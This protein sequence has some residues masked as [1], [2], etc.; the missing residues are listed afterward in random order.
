MD[1]E[2]STARQGWHL[3]SLLHLFPPQHQELLEYMRKLEAR[4]EKVA[5]E[6]WNEDAATEDEEAVAGLGLY[7]P[8]F[9]TP[10]PR[11][12]LPCWGEFH[13]T[14]PGSL[15]LPSVF[16]LFLPRLAIV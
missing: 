13:V 1:A 3:S 15:P 12:T 4:L 6:K 7:T 8:N 10:L 14:T 11:S 5:D 2:G 9:V 16:C